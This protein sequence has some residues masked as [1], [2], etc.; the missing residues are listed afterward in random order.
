MKKKLLIL[1]TLFIFLSCEK[2]EAPI[3][4]AI[5]LDKT[6]LTLKI[7]E[8]YKFNISYSP[9]DADAPNYIWSAPMV[10]L[11]GYS[12]NIIDIDQIGEVTAIHEGETELTVE[13]FYP[14]GG[15]V[16]KT[17]CKIIVIPVS[18]ESI[19]LN[20]NNIALDI[21][22]T[23]TLRYTI[24]PEN[25]TFQ[26]VVWKSDNS[27]TVKVNDGF[28]EPVSPG[29]ANIIINIKNT[30]I[31]DTCHIMV[32]P[33]K[34]E[35]I[36]INHSSWTSSIGETLNFVATI[37]PQNASNKN[38]IWSSSDENIASIDA[39]GIIT[40]K[41]IGDCYIIAKSEDGGYESKCK[42]TVAP[43]SLSHIRMDKY[44]YYIELGTNI[45][46]PISYYPENATNKKVTWT[47]SNP[48]SVSVDQNG[49]IKGVY[50]GSS[51]IIAT[52]DDNGYKVECRVEVCDFWMF[53]D[54]I[55]PSSSLII[56]GAN[57]SGTLYVGIK[58]NSTK[59]I[60]IKSMSI[61]DMNTY[62]EVD[63]ITES[64]S[65]GTLRPGEE[66]SIK[67]TLN[68]VYDPMFIFEYD[69]EGKEHDTRFQYRGNK[70][71]ANIN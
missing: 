9:Q 69:C 70:Q 1:F 40:T 5:N 64:N 71:S 43:I 37:Y 52:A 31:S 39:E 59:A 65:F 16:I 56:N 32:N 6:E 57:L 45:N 58:N 63:K 44:S 13:T 62:K 68:N 7:G 27:E 36:E 67:C 25:T 18:A 42:L 35:G 49:N 48:S 14:N 11:P 30:S 61:V 4:T 8:K 33:V 15:P 21:K 29:E 54:E 55:F 46:I 2:K 41:K 28:I 10:A 34:V 20:K 23:E 3:I 12:G 38:V 51:Q 66:M 53:L 24:T 19:K 60:D 17:K 22:D 26:D 50:L 47:S